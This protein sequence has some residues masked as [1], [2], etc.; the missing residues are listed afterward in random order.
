ME[1]ENTHP[2]NLNFVKRRT[3]PHDQLSKKR[4]SEENPLSHY[5]NPL[6]RK[7]DERMS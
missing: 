1:E 2:H 4:Q 6:W 5:L 3:K 7:E